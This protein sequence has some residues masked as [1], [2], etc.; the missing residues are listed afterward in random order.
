MN[1]FTHYLTSSLPLGDWA[2]NFVANGFKAVFI[3][4]M[5]SDNECKNFDDSNVF[6]DLQCEI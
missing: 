6:S 3:N 5:G 4:Y 2:T 1:E